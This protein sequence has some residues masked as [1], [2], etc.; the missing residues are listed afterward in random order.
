MNCVCCTRKGTQKYFN[1][2]AP[3]LFLKIIFKMRQNIATFAQI[4]IDTSTVCAE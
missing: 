3:Q 4:L 2:F 1:R